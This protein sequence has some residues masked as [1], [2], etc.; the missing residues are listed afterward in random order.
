M[1][2]QDPA[3]RRAYQNEWNRR[4]RSGE[5]P[6]GLRFNADREGENPTACWFRFHTSEPCKQQAEWVTV[7]TG[8]RWC[9]H[10]KTTL[11]WV[12]DVRPYDHEAEMNDQEE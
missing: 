3:K 11:D 5:K 2:I 8:T 6:S 4:R 7:T 1:G 10:H 9:D 12:G